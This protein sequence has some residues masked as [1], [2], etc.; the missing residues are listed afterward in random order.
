ME[1]FKRLGFQ[2]EILQTSVEHRGRTFTAE[3]LIVRMAGSGSSHQTLAFAGH[4]DSVGKGPGAADD[5]AAVG[6]C[7]GWMPPHWR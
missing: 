3:N 2:P 5:A 4:F 1:Q 7:A 6:R